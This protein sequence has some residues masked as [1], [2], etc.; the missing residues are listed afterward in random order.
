MLAFHTI[1]S[2]A[3]YNVILCMAATNPRFVRSY[4]SAHHHMAIGMQFGGKSNP[5]SYRAPLNSKGI[6][7][8][9]YTPTDRGRHMFVNG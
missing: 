7:L 2:S 3:N 5:F 6:E 4:G 1:T 9:A 8:I